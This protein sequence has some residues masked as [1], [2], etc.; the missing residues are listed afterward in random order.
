MAINQY[1]EQILSARYGEEVRQSIHDA[2]EQTYNDVAVDNF[3]TMRT[4]ESGTDLKNV[5]ETGAWNL[6]G[7]NEY[8]NSPIKSGLFLV[9]EISRVIYQVIFSG[10]TPSETIETTGD[11]VFRRRI[12]H[13]TEETPY[14]WT[15]DAIFHPDITPY[16]KS[17]QYDPKYEPGIRK[18]NRIILTE[19]EKGHYNNANGVLVQSDTYS[20]FRSPSSCAKD[21]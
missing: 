20:S 8:I 19:F 21:S 9:F 4:L 10:G 5:V 2:L 14:V 3:A 7:D 11:I 1:L 16:S 18:G 12:G 17:D 13:G 6:S 15:D